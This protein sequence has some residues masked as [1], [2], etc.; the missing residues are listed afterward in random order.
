MACN[1]RIQQNGVQENFTKDLN[2][3]KCA[4]L[5]RMS[6]MGAC[7]SSGGLCTYVSRENCANEFFPNI[8][9]SDSSLKSKGVYCSP[10]GN[11]ACGMLA[12]GLRGGF[13]VSIGIVKKFN[14]WRER[15]GC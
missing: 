4:N 14:Q 3:N 11:I 12:T 9:C 5:H 1:A 2:E 13:F 7:V 15:F 10:T 6:E 8:Y